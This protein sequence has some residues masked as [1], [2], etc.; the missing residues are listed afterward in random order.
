MC[1][2]VCMCAHVCVRVC[3]RG[4]DTVT[5]DYAMVFA[6][7]RVCV[8]VCVCL[9]VRVCVRVCVGGD[10]NYVM[11]FAGLVLSRCSTLR[12]TAMHCNT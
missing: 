3:A 9:Y 1:V 6:G 5:Y 2:C 11:V 7:V 10:D 4:D 8:Y 12:Q